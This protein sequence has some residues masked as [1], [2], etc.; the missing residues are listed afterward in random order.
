MLQY[1]FLLII[2]VFFCAIATI[3]S[4]QSSRES[5]DS[6]H[7]DDGPHDYSLNLSRATFIAK[8]AE[9]YANKIGLSV[10]IAV[11]DAGGHALTFRR[12]DGASPL[13]AKIVEAKAVGSALFNRDGAVLES[14]YRNNLGF[15]TQVDKLA[16]LPLIPG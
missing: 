7:D 3:D 13:S 9:D 12:M 5:H 4:S 6:H 16:P 2:L 15:F 11:C 10:S 14:I 1:S 8:T